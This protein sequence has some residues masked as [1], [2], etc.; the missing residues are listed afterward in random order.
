MDRFRIQALE[1]ILAA[2]VLGI[3]DQAAALETL[4]EKTAVM[5]QGA[6]KRGNRTLADTYRDKQQK[7]SRTHCMTDTA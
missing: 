3:E 2:D 5:I 7:Y 4:R 1:K 6:V